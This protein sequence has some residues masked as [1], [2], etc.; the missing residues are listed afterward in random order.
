MLDTLLMRELSSILLLAYA[1]LQDIKDREIDSLIWRSMVLLGVAY[2]LLDVISLGFYELFRPFIFIL[3]MAAV[4]AFALERLGLIGGGD[5]KLLIG[6]GAMFPF[7]PPG[8][9]ILPAVFIS[10]FT[11]AIVLALM[12]NVGFFLS[13]LKHIKEA[14][15]IWEVL[16]LFVAQKKDAEEL[17]RFESVL[18]EGR[19]FIGTRKAEFGAASRKGDVWAVPALPFAVFISFGLIISIFYGDLLHLLIG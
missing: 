19:I 4:F 10:V 3:A 9:F 11:N 17:G 2:F 13:N 16:R 14:K 1:S 15:S 18:E 12:V 6:L 7:L 5:A 8:E